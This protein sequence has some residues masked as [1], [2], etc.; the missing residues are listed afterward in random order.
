MCRYDAVPCPNDCT[1]MLSR[2]CVEDHVE[3]TCPRRKVTCQS[4]GK[5]F[6]GEM[7]EVCND[8]HVVEVLRVLTDLLAK[9]R[10]VHCGEFEGIKVQARG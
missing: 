4:C 7:M 10:V 5:E 9:P 2:M 1:A 8:D 6:S 3:Y